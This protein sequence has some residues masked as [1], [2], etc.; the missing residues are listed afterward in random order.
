LG[1]RCFTF[2][3][4]SALPDEF[5]K[6]VL[7]LRACSLHSGSVQLDVFHGMFP[8][9]LRTLNRDFKHI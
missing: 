3:S 2:E 9:F 1:A 8:L 4:S 7:D 6:L 5:R